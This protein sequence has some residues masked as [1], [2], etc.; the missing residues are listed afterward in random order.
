MLCSGKVDTAIAVSHVLL[1][2]ASS[3]CRSLWIQRYSVYIQFFGLH[4]QSWYVFQCGLYISFWRTRTSH[5]ISALNDMINYFIYS[6]T[7]KEDVSRLTFLFSYVSIR[8]F[9]DDP[10]PLSF[11]LSGAAHKL[12]AGL[13]S[14]VIVTNKILIISAEIHIITPAPTQTNPAW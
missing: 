1:V 5:L 12:E 4:E 8:Y 10:H 9:L 11:L 2:C 6:N 13:W 14:A 3:D 7:S